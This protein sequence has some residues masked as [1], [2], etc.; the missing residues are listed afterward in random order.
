VIAVLDL[1]SGIGGFSLGLERTGGFRT[2]GFCEI[3][4][5]PRA[6]LR[7]H[8][9][10][11]PIFE[12]VRELHAGDIAGTVD[13]ICGGYPCQP[14]SL[15]GKRKGAADDRHLWPEMFRLVKEVRPSWVC[16]ENVAG[17][18]N[19]GLDQVLS[20]LEGEGYETAAFII[21]AVSVDAPHRRDR[22]WIVAYAECTKRRKGQSRGNVCD[23]ENAER[24]E[25][26][27]KFGTSSADGG[28]GSVPNATSTRLSQGKSKS[29]GKVWDETRRQEF[30]GRSAA[31]ANTS[32]NLLNGCRYI[33][34]EGRIEPANSGGD[35]AHANQQRLEKRNGI[36]SRVARPPPFECSRW[37][38]EPGVGRV[39]HGVP[40][41]VDRLRSLG[42]A[43]V[44]QVVEVIGRAI[45]AAH[46]ETNISTTNNREEQP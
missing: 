21:P 24:K 15:A 9:P 1:F 43:V 3:E 34:K 29:S 27:G 42:N 19:M 31:V 44:P 2:V 11:V 33:G 36:G 7:K 6:V 39:A 22:V 45:L 46:Y 41:R 23:G 26:A 17:H 20:D 12:D 38:T 5:F 18:V 8:W 13:L 25:A 32:L 16:A 35:A 28:E 37:P 30:S 4:K 10:D 14:F 40:R